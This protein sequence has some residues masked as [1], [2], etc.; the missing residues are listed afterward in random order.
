M[1]ND[2]FKYI[3][4]LLKDRPKTKAGLIRYLWPEIREALNAGYTLKEI[5][6]GLNG[7][8]ISIGYSRLRTLVARLRRI[9]ITETERTVIISKGARIQSGS[10]VSD[11]A[12]A[13]QE[14]RAR[15]IKFDHNPFSTRIK[16]LI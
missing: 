10:A 9:D 14:Q 12:S 2:D 4:E 8:G 11:V 6:H 15:K 3:Q 13:L 1:A 16:D 7:K 5:C